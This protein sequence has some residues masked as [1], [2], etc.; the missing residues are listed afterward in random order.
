MVEVTV[1]PPLGD[2]LGAGL[3][4]GHWLN[5]MLAATSTGHEIP[6]GRRARWKRAGKAIG[7]S[8]G[9]GRPASVE[10]HHNAE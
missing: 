6:S 5:R 10:D 3:P 8:R 4:F 1:P 2:R 7:K 9:F